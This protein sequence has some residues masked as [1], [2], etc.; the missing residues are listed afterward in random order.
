M[1]K[2]EKTLAIITWCDADDI[3]NYGQVLQGCAMAKTFS[4]MEFKKVIVISYRGRTRREIFN[5]FFLHFF[6]KK[7]YRKTRLFIKKVMS[8]SR[9]EFHQVFSD[10]EVEQLTKDADVLVCGSDQIWHPIVFDRIFFLDCGKKDAKRIAY[11]ASQP[12][13]KVY[14]EY[15][16][17]YQRM[18]MYLKQFDAIMEALLMIREKR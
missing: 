2:R 9:V 1:E 13:K 12:M 3:V 15:I 4:S 18:Q 5:Y 17:I 6:T 11:A 8:Q 7:S 10:T 14:P 16:R